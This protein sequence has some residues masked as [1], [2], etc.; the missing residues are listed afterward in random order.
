[1]SSFCLRL[2]LMFAKVEKELTF[3]AV[4]TKQSSVFQAIHFHLRNKVNAR[5][6]MMILKSDSIH[7]TLNYFDWVVQL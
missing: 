1:M 5:F 7:I 4:T 3:R 6:E 2:R